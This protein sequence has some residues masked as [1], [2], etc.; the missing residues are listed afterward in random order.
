MLKPLQ[1]TIQSLIIF[2]RAL[3]K[4]VT[5]DISFRFLPY[6]NSFSK[7]NEPINATATD[8]AHSFQRRVLHFLI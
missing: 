7:N 6:Y 2:D 8:T 4:A 3:K 1:I 5:I